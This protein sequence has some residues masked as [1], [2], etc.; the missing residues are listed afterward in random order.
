MHPHLTLGMD[1]NM[2]NDTM[3]MDMGPMMPMP[4]FVYWTADTWF[5]F[6]T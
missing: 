1:M 5:L 3:G 4:M 2:S 6:G